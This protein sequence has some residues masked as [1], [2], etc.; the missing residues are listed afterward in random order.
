MMIL[1]TSPIIAFE[2]DDATYAKSSN[3]ASTDKGDLSIYFDGME[4]NE[5]FDLTNDSGNYPKVPQSNVEKFYLGNV[6][7]S[8]QGAFRYVTEEKIESGESDSLVFAT[9]RKIVVS[10]SGTNSATVYAA[11]YVIALCAC[12]IAGFLLTAMLM[13]IAF[14]EKTSSHLLLKFLNVV[15]VLIGLIIGVVIVTAA[16]KTLSLVDSDSLAFRISACAVIHF[17]LSVAYVFVSKKS[18]Y[19]I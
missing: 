18:K 3:T 6:D 4:L 16:N 17:I 2:I 5:I 19:S 8:A 13:S 9:V 15:F 10:V 14:E 7:S 12:M 11:V 1:S